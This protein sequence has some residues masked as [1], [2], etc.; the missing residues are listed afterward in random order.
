VKDAIHVWGDGSCH[1]NPGPGGYAA[2]VVDPAS[3]TVIAKVAG[4]EKLTTNQRMELLAAIEGLK[5]F[6]QMALG[7]PVAFHSDSLYVVKG[8]REWVS[9]WKR[10]G[11]KKAGNEPVANVDLWQR[12]DGVAQRLTVTWEHVRG[13]ANIAYNEMCDQLANEQSRLQRQT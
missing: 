7:R 12:L 10:R 3:D 4:G 8:M 6:E 2:V 1:G 9:G 13:H 5:C 11:W